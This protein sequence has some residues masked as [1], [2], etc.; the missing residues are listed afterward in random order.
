M[1]EITPDTIRDVIAN[2][3]PLMEA[4]SFLLKEIADEA[5]TAVESVLSVVG[6]DPAQLPVAFFI[7]AML[8][9]AEKH[10]RPIASR[11]EWLKI[12]DAYVAVKAV[13]ESNP[14]IKAQLEG[15]LGRPVQARQVPAS[16]LPVPSVS[17]LENLLNGEF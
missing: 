10:F 3:N 2:P 15:Q 17:E 5:V 11:E 6:S 9:E 8:V 12:Y 1:Q 13:I 7:Q 4:L 16:S 14:D